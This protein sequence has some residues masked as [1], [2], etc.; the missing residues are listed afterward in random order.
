MKNINTIDLLI[1]K[2]TAPNSEMKNRLVRTKA[3]YNV[4]YD[5]D[6]PLS[7]SDILDRLEGE[8]NCC[9]EKVLSDRTYIGTAHIAHTLNR[10]IVAG[11]ASVSGSREIWF[12]V[13]KETKKRGEVYLYS[14]N[15]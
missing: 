12:N 11:I 10:F 6:A 13:N 3:V 5:A 9:G 7:A 1:L 14:L 8:K 2:D 4:L 15:R